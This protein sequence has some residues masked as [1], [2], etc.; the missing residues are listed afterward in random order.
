MMK[1]IFSYMI[2]I[3]LVTTSFADVTSSLFPNLF[4]TDINNSR[5]TPS[6]S[7]NKKQFLNK[8]VAI[9]NNKPITSIELER[10]VAKF[11]SM[12]SNPQFNQD[13]L[14]IKRLALQ[15]LISQQVLLQLAEQNNINVSEQQTDTAIKD[16]AMKNN[17]SIDSLRLNVEASGMSFESYKNRYII[18]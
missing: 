7:S 16:I 3:L 1:K 13:T 10:E 2:A 12:N 5:H 17:V 11:E 9:V 15:D 6:I 8:T 4:H 18:N 14:A